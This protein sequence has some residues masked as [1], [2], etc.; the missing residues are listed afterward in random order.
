MAK[1][2]A[3]LTFPAPSGDLE[4]ERRPSALPEPRRRR[5]REPPRHSLGGT[6]HH[7]VQ[8]QFRGAIDDYP[9]QG[10]GPRSGA[11]GPYRAGPLPQ[12]RGQGLAG[13]TA[14]V[15]GPGSDDGQHAPRADR[16]A[17]CGAGQGLLPAHGLPVRAEGRR[18]GAQAAPAG[19]PGGDVL[20]RP[21]AAFAQ[22]HGQ[23]APAAAGNRPGQR[24][25]LRRHRMA[26]Q[27]RGG[28]LPGR[29]PALRAAGVLDAAGLRDQLQ[30]VL[31]RPPGALQGSQLPWLRRCAVPH[32]RQ[33]GG[34]MGRRQR[35]PALLPER[36]HHRRTAGPAGAGGEHAPAPATAGRAVLRHRPGPGLQ[37]LLRADRQGCPRQGLGAAAGRDRHRQG[38]HRP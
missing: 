8:R 1:A 7:P 11:Q 38:S 6:R 33:A 24:P 35:L 15:A 30:L 28:E 22:G 36:P 5:R 37:A 17:R 4:K 9:I 25:L 21:A 16:D 3:G 18:A 32:R 23:G 14:H 2:G 31:P 34:A 29:E 19:Q 12:H 20:H 26:G 27:L 13:R 10:A